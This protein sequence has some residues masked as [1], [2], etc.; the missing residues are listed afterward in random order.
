MDDEFK[1]VSTSTV[2]VFIFIISGKFVFPKFLRRIRKF[3]CLMIFSSL[4]SEKSDNSI[5]FF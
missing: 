3:E 5:G 4:K 1:G 2:I